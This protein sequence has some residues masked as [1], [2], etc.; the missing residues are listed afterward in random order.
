MGIL[1]SLQDAQRFWKLTRGFASLRSAQPL[2][3]FLH[4]FGVSP[5]LMPMWVYASLQPLA[6]FLNP[7]FGVI[8]LEFPLRSH[9]VWLRLCCS[10]L[11]LRTLRLRGELAYLSILP[12]QKFSEE[13]GEAQIDQGREETW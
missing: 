6:I 5:S 9:A 4:P 12:P 8:G 11:S 3:T 13:Q 2:A 7:F 1:A 10:A